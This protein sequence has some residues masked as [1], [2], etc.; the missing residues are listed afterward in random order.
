[1]KTL[2]IIL[3]G[4]AGLSV[5]E[6]QQYATVRSVKWAYYHSLPDDASKARFQEECK[7]G[8]Y[9]EWAAQ[10]AA[11]QNAEIDRQMAA[12]QARR[13]EASRAGHAWLQQEIARQDASRRH[14]GPSITERIESLERNRRDEEIRRLPT[15]GVN[16]PGR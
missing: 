1:M 11:R 4:C 10:E 5:A 9:D 8:L 7:A 13:A 14:P 15:P 2:L 3:M 12:E 6:A 16:I